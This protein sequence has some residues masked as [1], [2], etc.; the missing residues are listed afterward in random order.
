MNSIKSKITDIAVVIAL[1]S[2]VISVLSVLQS[3]VV[4]AYTLP[5]QNTIAKTDK[6]YKDPALECTGNKCNLMRKYVNPIIAFLAAVAGI[7]ITA[8]IIMGG[9]RYAA[10]GDDPAKVGAAKKQISTAILA[11]VCLL[12]LYAGLRWLTPT[13]L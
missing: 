3:S 13:L 1:T 2:G 5:P 6:T 9:L 4:S 8:G 7:A 10:A 12:L 11:L